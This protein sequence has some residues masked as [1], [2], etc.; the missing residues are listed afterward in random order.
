VP[1]KWT[2]RLLETSHKVRVIRHA[3][4]YVFKGGYPKKRR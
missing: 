2:K 3:G 4:R 1:K